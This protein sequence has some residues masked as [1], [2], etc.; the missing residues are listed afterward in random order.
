MSH[1][2]TTKGVP[3]LDLETLQRAFQRLGGT[4]KANQKTFQWF[5]TWVG[6]TSAPLEFFSDEERARFESLNDEARREWLT[7]LFG[8]CDHAVQFPDCS[9]EVGVVWKGGRWHLL[10][11]SWYSGGLDK[12]LGEA[13]SESPFNRAYSEAGI[14]LDAERQGWSWSESK[15][16][17]GNTLIEVETW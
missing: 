14:I 1:I 17:N 6:N 4:F 12:V 13:G 15:C 3:F 8:H 10:W 7:E 2:I 9:Y 11:D 16:V 5:G